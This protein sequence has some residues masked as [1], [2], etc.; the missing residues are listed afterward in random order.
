MSTSK[1]TGPAV[2]FRVVV[3]DD[4]FHVARLHTRI[5]ESVEGFGVVATAGTAAQAAAAI[6]AERPDLVLADIYLPDGSGLDLIAGRDVDAIVLS[7]AVATA[8][9][10]KAL[11]RGA[12]GYLIKPFADD[13]LTELLRAYGRYRNLVDSQ[14]ELDQEAVDRARRVLH[15]AGARDGASRRSPTETAV[16][17]ALAEAG[18]ALSAPMVADRVGVSRATAQRYLSALAHQGHLVVELRY[19]STGR[20]EHR[21]RTAGRT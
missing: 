6:E 14:A 8:A 18:A 17:G 20:P 1:D 16:L 2:R 7:A 10:R 21:Y 15:G 4:D 19:G 11:Q 12:F 9:V 13:D 3:V 5:V